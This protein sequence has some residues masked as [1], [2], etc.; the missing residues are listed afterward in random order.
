MHDFF[1][2]LIRLCTYSRDIHVLNGFCIKNAVFIRDV[3]HLFITD[4][5]SYMFERVK[6]A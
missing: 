1:A 4:L 5:N 3:S 2:V 6:I